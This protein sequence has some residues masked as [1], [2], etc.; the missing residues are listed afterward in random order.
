MPVTEKLFFLN[1]LKAENDYRNDFMT[2]LQESY[3]AKLQFKLATPRSAAEVLL[4]AIWNQVDHNVPSFFFFLY[5]IYF[6][7]LANQ[8]K[9]KKETLIGWAIKAI[10]KAGVETWAQ[11]FKTNDVFS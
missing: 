4:I 2:A 1:Q 5:H 9:P 3:T 8:N 6:K 7:K 10:Y 11:L